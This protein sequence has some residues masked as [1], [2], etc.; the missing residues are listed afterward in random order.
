MVESW[1]GAAQES[2]VSCQTR[3]NEAAQSLAAVLNN[4]SQSVGAAFDNYSSTHNATIQ[5]WSS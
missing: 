2:Y 3:W 5:V 1:S 4:V